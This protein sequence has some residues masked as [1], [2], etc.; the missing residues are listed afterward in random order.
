MKR[1]TIL[2]LFALILAAPKL[3]ATT[4]EQPTETNTGPTTA[5]KDLR[6]IGSTK[7][8]K[9]GA[10]LENFHLTGTLTIDA[11]NVT[12][13]NFIVNGSSWYGIQVLSGAKN[14]VFEDGEVT[15]TK[16]AGI[17]GSNY[18]ARRLHVHHV[19]KD[20]IKIGSNI[21][22]ES[23]YIHHVG[24]PA[25]N[26]DVHADGI[27]SVGGSNVL[28]RWN[29]IDVPIGKDGYLN[30]HAIIIQAQNSPVDA[31]RIEDNWLNGGGF[32]VQLR[33]KKGGTGGE[34]TNSFI[35]YNRYGPDA[36]HGPWYT[37]GDVQ[38]Y[39]NRYVADNT[40]IAGQ[41]SPGASPS[42]PSNLS[43]TSK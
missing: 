14:A 24:D 20:A 29:N 4:P 18:T 12:I 5:V 9:D 11:S 38:K 37:T 3:L 13:R 28:I 36:S 10:V 43:L 8:T 17:M 25:L 32:T 35:T 23:C 21:V 39:E 6:A 2:L 30:H 22:I 34:P 15:G 19:G 1:P 16:S 33:S 42:S 27:Q 40:L 7:I 31:V 26:P 41:T